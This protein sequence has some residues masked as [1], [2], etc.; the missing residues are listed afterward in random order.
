M[1]ETCSWNLH[2]PLLHPKVVLLEEHRVLLDILMLM[3]RIHAMGV[4]GQYATHEFR[5]AHVN[6]LGD[7]LN[8][9]LTI[10]FIFGLVEL[11]LALSLLRVQHDTP[12]VSQ[13]LL[14]VI[15]EPVMLIMGVMLVVS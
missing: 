15:L 8:H 9:D 11:K 10:N 3:V 5:D 4:L 12:S 13:S 7:L 2:I 14:H 1:G 6:K